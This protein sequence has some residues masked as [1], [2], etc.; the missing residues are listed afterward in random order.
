MFTSSTAVAETTT[1]ADY[2]SKAAQEI[3]VILRSSSFCPLIVP[4]DI[5]QPKSS[6]LGEIPD[7]VQKGHKN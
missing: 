7:R 1:V 3:D 5:Q 2:K 6:S 4:V